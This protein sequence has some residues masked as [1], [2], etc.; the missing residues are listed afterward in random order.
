MQVLIKQTN[1]KLTAE[2]KGIIIEKISSLD[3]YYPKIIRARVEVEKSTGQKSG[4][5]YRAELNI[6]LPQRLLRIEKSTSDWRKS[7]EKIKD[8]AKRSLSREKKKLIDK[9]RRK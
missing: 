6:Q 1:I 9:N 8:H 4:D 7:V 3:K 2:E 5:V